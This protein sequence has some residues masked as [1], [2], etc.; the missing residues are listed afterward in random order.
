MIRQGLGVLV[1][2]LCLAGCGDERKIDSK[3]YDLQIENSLRAADSRD[4]KIEVVNGDDVPVIDS[5]QNEEPKSPPSL[6]ANPELPRSWTESI[7]LP[8]TY[9]TPYFYT[10]DINTDGNQDLAF[11]LP[12][13]NQLMILESWQNSF[14]Y[15]FLSLSDR[16]SQSVSLPSYEHIFVQAPFNFNAALVADP[17]SG[18]DTSLD[19]LACDPLE[20]RLTL[21]LLQATTGEIERYDTITRSIGKPVAVVSA[22][23]NRD[24]K[25]DFAALNADS[26]SITVAY[27]RGDATFSGNWI[28]RHR[29]FLRSTPYDL[30]VSE[31]NRDGRPDLLVIT[32]TGLEV[33]LGNRLGT[34]DSVRPVAMEKIPRRSLRFLQANP[35]DDYST[36]ILF[37]EANTDFFVAL[38]GNSDGNFRQAEGF[39]PEL[40]QTPVQVIET[41]DINNDGQD[42]F[43]VLTKK[44]ELLYYQQDSNVFRLEARWQPDENA[45]WYNVKIFDHNQDGKSDFVV[46]ESDGRQF[47]LRFFLQ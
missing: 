21:F 16:S 35:L 36:D 11:Y 33:F 30:Y 22:D 38:H 25:A 43:V 37:V 2:G 10:L 14:L 44:N 9:G 39:P 15:R 31:L 47:R 46:V 28:G 8:L 5:I 26:N 45:Q 29:Y 23:F 19:I 34:L 3:A 27:G 40:L 24:Q 6:P 32:E 18:T 1:V 20:D 12:E 13:S 42:D 17:D 41:A 7:P 4:S